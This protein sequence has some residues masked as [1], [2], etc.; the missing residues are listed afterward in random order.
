MTNMFVG[1]IA[2]EVSGDIAELAGD[3]EMVDAWELAGGRGR[4]TWCFIL[5]LF[6]TGRRVGTAAA[7]SLA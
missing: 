5:M 7:L 6:N 2:A 4:G 3:G 1:R